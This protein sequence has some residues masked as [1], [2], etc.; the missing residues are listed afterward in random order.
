MAKQIIVTDEGRKKLVD[1]LD[2]LKNVKR[3]EV[4]EGLRLALSF[5][6][7]SENSEYDEAKNEQA[8]VEAQIIELEETLKN[9]KILNDSDITTDSV[10]VGSTVKVFDETYNEET[11]YSIVGPTEADPINGKISD[12][13]P[14]GA[15]LLGAK[16]GQSVSINTPGG[17]VTLKII[18]IEKR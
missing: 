5:G 11:D 6:D 2:Y 7:I 16:R 10:G 12:Q 15:A 4:V 1:E 14:I 8:K 13:S 18:N 17:T 9:I 3:K